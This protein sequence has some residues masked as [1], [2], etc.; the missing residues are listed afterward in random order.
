MREP[1]TFPGIPKREN[2]LSRR[3][4]MPLY[5]PNKDCYYHQAFLDRGLESPY[6]DKWLSGRD[7]D[8]RINA[9][10][11]VDNAV[12]RKSL[13]CSCDPSRS[14]FALLVRIARRSSRRNPPIRGVHVV[15]VSY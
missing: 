14:Q 5:G 11:P 13:A 9:M 7:R 6:D 1:A 3:S 4:C 8:D 15:E 12:R 2:P 10:V